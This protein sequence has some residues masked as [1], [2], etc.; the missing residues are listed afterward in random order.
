MQYT[1]SSPSGLCLYMYTAYNTS[2]HLLQVDLVIMFRVVM[3]FIASTVCSPLVR[4]CLVSC[5]LTVPGQQG[6]P[7][8]YWTGEGGICIQHC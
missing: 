8:L 7:L 2:P 4:Q 3:I 1:G 5:P 6:A